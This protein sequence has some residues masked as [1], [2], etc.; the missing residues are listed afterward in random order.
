MG[1]LS[2]RAL[3]EREPYERRLRQPAARIAFLLGMDQ[4]TVRT[5]K[6]LPP[7]SRI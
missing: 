7:A 1:P 4:A 3:T 6:F 5:G 2:A